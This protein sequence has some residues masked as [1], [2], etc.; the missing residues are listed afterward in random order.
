MENEKD[1][2]NDQ[3]SIEDQKENEEYTEAELARF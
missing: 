3:I 2:E 1:K